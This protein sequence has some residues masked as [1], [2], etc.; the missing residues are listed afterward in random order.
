MFSMFV[1]KTGSAYLSKIIETTSRRGGIHKL[2][3]ISTKFLQVFEK[4]YLVV[5]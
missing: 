3:I 5:T 1:E 2:Y 4:F